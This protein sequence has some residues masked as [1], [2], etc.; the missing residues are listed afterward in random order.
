[1]PHFSLLTQRINPLFSLFCLTHHL[2]LAKATHSAVSR[3]RGKKK[4]ATVPV[5]TATLTVIPSTALVPL[6]FF[7]FTRL[8]CFCGEV[9]DRG[10]CRVQQPGMAILLSCNTPYST[11]GPLSQLLAQESS[12]QRGLTQNLCVSSPLV[13]IFSLSLSVLSLRGLFL[14]QARRL[15]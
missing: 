14:A 3:Q 7:R 6:P 1:M 2:P 5:A 9:D 8:G 12:R 11:G 4:N 15:N 10:L 13:P